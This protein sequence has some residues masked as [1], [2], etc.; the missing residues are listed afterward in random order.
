MAKI[1]GWKLS[2]YQPNPE[3]P[4]Y[5]VDCQLREIR[6][7]PD[8]WWSPSANSYVLAEVR[9]KETWANTP[10]TDRY[11]WVIDGKLVQLVS[12]NGGGEVRWDVTKDRVERARAQENEAWGRKGDSWEYLCAARH[13]GLEEPTW[14]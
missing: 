4:R 7:T 6:T 13:F 2:N 12:I 1:H 10:A 9:N 11:F 8:V 5:V 14:A 3:H